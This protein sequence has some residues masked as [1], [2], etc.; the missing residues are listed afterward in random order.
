MDLIQERHAAEDGLELGLQNVPVLVDPK[1]RQLDLRHSVR[2][3]VL[4]GEM[5]VRAERNQILG[6]VI[7]G[8]LVDV[9]KMRTCLA[10]DSA[11]V[12][13]LSEHGIT[14]GLGDRGSNLGHAE[15]IVPVTAT[16]TSRE[17]AANC[18]RAGRH[19]GAVRPALSTRSDPAGRLSQSEI[20]RSIDAVQECRP[21]RG[22]G[23]RHRQMCWCRPSGDV[24]CSRERH[25]DR[26]L[27]ELERGAAP[28]AERGAARRS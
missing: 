7:R 1:E 4:V 27:H 21:P 11:A 22:G 12:V 28:P 26:A 19:N 17:R 13:E 10:A 18:R 14:H 9:M 15:I 8:V 24:P 6:W 23:G 2:C 25:D 20:I 16:G 5:A 3:I